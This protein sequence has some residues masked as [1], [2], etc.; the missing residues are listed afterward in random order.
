MN[1]DTVVAPDDSR[2]HAITD[3]QRD[4]YY[5][6]PTLR[7]RWATRFDRSQLPV[8]ASSSSVRQVTGS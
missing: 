5:V 3:A 4:A 7:T 8:R 6:N 2:Y 1:V